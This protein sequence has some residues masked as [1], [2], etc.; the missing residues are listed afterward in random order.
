MHSSI[1]TCRELRIARD[2]ILRCSIAAQA[3]GKLVTYEVTNAG[4]YTLDA[5]DGTILD[6]CLFPAAHH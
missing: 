4:M 1:L 6:L 3:A 5:A 2:R